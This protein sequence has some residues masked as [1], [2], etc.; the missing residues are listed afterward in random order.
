MEAFL[1]YPTYSSWGAL[2]R[3]RVTS[4][5]CLYRKTSQRHL[6]Q[7]CAL[8]HRH[9]RPPQVSAGSS[10]IVSHTNVTPCSNTGSKLNCNGAENS[11]VARR[12]SAAEGLEQPAD[13]P[14]RSIQTKS[15]C[16]PLNNPY[17]IFASCRYLLLLL[18][19]V[20]PLLTPLSPPCW[21]PVAPVLQ[22]DVPALVSAVLS[23]T[24]SSFTLHFS[25]TCF[26]SEGAWS[27]AD[28]WLCGYD[29]ASG[30][31]DNG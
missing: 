17:Y 11:T 2:N 27:G 16:F 7:H 19:N 3:E 8:H 24:E 12:A 23:D 15:T 9:P 13:D 1:K 22:P 31:F 20:R 4:R 6:R 25:S 10:S 21:C 28:V 26:C 18:P 5:A 29:I 30:Q 14:W